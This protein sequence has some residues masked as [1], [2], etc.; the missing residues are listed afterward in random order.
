MSYPFPFYFYVL[1]RFL[2]FLG[3]WKGGIGD[4]EVDE[5]VWQ[6][7][8]MEIRRVETNEVTGLR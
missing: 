7:E 4:G 5:V 8:L 1:C 6:L 3:G 2:C